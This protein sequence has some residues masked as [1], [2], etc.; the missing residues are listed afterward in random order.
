[1]SEVAELRGQLEEINASIA[2]AEKCLE[3]GPPLRDKIERQ[4]KQTISD[5]LE[6]PES[7]LHIGIAVMKQYS[8]E[9]ITHGIVIDD[10]NQKIRR[11]ARKRYKHHGRLEVQKRNLVIEAVTT[12]PFARLSPDDANFK[13]VEEAQEYI[14]SLGFKRLM[15]T[16]CKNTIGIHGFKKEDGKCVKSTEPYAMQNLIWYFCSLD[17]DGMMRE[18]GFWSYNIGEYVCFCCA[19]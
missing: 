12:D 14:N 2:D 15:K 8:P 6:V 16:H 1:M 17:L 11:M 9:T 5:T 18:L 13:V 4:L 10:I 7:Q 19:M 3:E